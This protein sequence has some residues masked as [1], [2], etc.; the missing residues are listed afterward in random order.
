MNGWVA[1]GLLAGLA[2]IVML[3]P[4]KM[5]LRQWQIAL[6]TLLLGMTGYA[7]QGRPTLAPSPAKPVTAQAEAAT[8]LI[9]TRGKMDYKFGVAKRWLRSAD[10]MARAGN[11]PL[12]AGFIQGGLHEY[13]KDGDLW[14]ALGLQLM[15]ASDGK[16]T[17]PAQIA[18]DKARKYS[19]DN[20]APDY[21][22]GLDALFKRDPA[23]AERL[24]KGILDRSPKWPEWRADL[25]SQYAALQAAR[26]QIE[27]E[28]Q[29][30]SK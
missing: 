2:F 17:P 6:S 10:G 14:A 16:I 26:K 12:A 28:A 27:A 24:W 15:L 3:W 22:T 18:F 9:E 5:A 23:T 1:L 20:P 29:S 21:F 4:G 19:P 8:L 30:P 13:P 7:L 11:Y 25:E